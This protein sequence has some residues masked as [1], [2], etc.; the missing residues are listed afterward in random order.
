MAVGVVDLERRRRRAR[1]A[2][3]AEPLAAEH[4]Q[5]VR[6]ELL[7]V[8]LVTC[9]VAPS[10]IVTIVITD[11]TPITMPRIVSDERS[12]LRRI[13]RSASTMCVPEHHAGVLTGTF[14]VSL[15]MRPSRKR[16]MRLVQRGDVRLVR[17]HRDRDAAL[18]R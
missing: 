14:V 18:A 15:S 11:A 5:Q 13:S 9:A 8:G 4:L 6:A 2:A 7:D 17:D 10:P 12:T 1:A 3:A 16:T